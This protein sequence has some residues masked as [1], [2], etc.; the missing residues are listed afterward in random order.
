MAGDGGRSRGAVRQG[1][2]CGGRQG[3]GVTAG[4]LSSRGLWRSASSLSSQL[5]PLHSPEA[6][7]VA[8]CPS[9]TGRTGC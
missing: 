1:A 5:P 3:Q 6:A 8:S 7:A 9:P 2:G 4:D